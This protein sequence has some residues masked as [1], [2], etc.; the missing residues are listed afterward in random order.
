MVVVE[1]E[2][3]VAVAVAVV[4]VIEKVLLCCSQRRNHG[5]RREHGP[6]PGFQG[7][8]HAPEAAHA[9]PGGAGGAVRQRAGE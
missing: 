5:E 2:E 6:A 1:E 8:Q 4:V 3:V 7:P 9:R